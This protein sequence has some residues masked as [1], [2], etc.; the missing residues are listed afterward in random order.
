MTAHPHYTMT[1]IQGTGEQNIVEMASAL[2][3]GHKWPEIEA[4]ICEGSMELFAQFDLKSLGSGDVA[5]NLRYKHDGGINNEVVRNTLKLLKMTT[6]PI[7]ITSVSRSERYKSVQ[8]LED[9]T[10][11]VTNN[12][13]KGV[14]PEDTVLL[15]EFLRAMGITEEKLK[16]LRPSTSGARYNSYLADMLS[17]IYMMNSYFHPEIFDKVIKVPTVYNTSMVGEDGEPFLKGLSVNGR[18]WNPKEGFDY[19]YFEE[20]GP[21]K[22]GVEFRVPKGGSIGK[23]YHQ[24][25]EL[26]SL[27][28]SGVKEMVRN[29]FGLRGTYNRFSDYWVNDVDDGFTMLMILNAYNHVSLTP[30]EMKVKAEIEKV[31]SEVF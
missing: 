19:L 24:L 10:V 28:E 12:A 22:D 9:G 13:T 2:N 18:E 16:V 17:F 8:F 6:L 11:T 3:F 26:L 5:S 25:S 20:D 15:T 27:K 1:K 29:F 4:E 21:E 23:V 7:T 30:D 31:V 14:I